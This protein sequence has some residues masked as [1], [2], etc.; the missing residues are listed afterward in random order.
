MDQSQG[1]AI[2]I[3]HVDDEPG[4]LKTSKQCLELETGFKVETAGSV[5]EALH[6]LKMKKFDAI[7]AD[8]MMPG[9]DGLQ[10][11]KELRDRGDH[12]PFIVFTGNRHLP[13]KTRASERYL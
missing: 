9:K 6:K 11:L 12:I 8:Y 3:L 4:F 1:T 10:F 13:T 5:D 7:I 2:N